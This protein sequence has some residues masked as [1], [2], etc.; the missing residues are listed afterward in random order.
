MGTKT[1]TPREGWNQHEVTARPNV[2]HTEM[3][4][5]QAAERQTHQRR[6]YD[7]VIVRGAW[8]KSRRGDRKLRRMFA[9]N[10]L[11]KGFRP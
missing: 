9:R 4:E 10:P 3:L 6:Q 1:G 8:W 11:T 5:R 2:G 7:H